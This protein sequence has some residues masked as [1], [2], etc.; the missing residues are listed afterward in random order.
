MSPFL[1]NLCQTLKIAAS[2]EVGKV[3][4]R[5][6]YLQGQPSYLLRYKA[7]AYPAP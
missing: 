7:A 4:G 2:N 3:I 6:E 5:C 1:F